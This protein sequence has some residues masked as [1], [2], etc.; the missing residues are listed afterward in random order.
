MPKCSLSNFHTGG[1]SGDRTSRATSRAVATLKWIWNKATQTKTTPIRTYTH[2]NK[3]YI[4]A[5]YLDCATFEDGTN[6][7]AA[8]WDHKEKVPEF[9]EPD[10][11]INKRVTTCWPQLLRRKY[12]SSQVKKRKKK[13]TGGRNGWWQF[14]GRLWY[15]NL[16]ESL[17]PFVPLIWNFWPEAALDL[18]QPPL[19][20]DLPPWSLLSH[21][22]PAIL[23]QLLPTTPMNHHHPAP[24]SAS[25]LLLPA[26]V[27][28]VR[29]GWM[30]VSNWRNHIVGLLLT[31]EAMWLT[32]G[33]AA[34]MLRSRYTYCGTETRT[35]VLVEPDKCLCQTS[36]ITI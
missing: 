13:K 36:F 2:I 14:L 3:C 16:Q 27:Y 10:G 8:D 4:C 23:P 26:R 29:V 15:I 12:P 19:G 31:Q 9:T 35:H 28:G 1:H 25:I 21:L 11:L 17:A 5:S 20:F 24:P 32:K 18:S 33:H 6:R 30:G 22:H 34:P 7:W